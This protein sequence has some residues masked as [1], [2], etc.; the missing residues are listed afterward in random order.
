MRD[1]G[2][3]IS[4]FISRLR[5]VSGRTGLAETDRPAPARTPSA[6]APRPAGDLDTAPDDGDPHPAGPSP[7]ARENGGAR[8]PRA[9]AAA[10]AATAATTAADPAA[11]IG[12][13]AERLRRTTPEPD[14]APA[15]TPAVATRVP[16]RA[17]AQEKA[18]DWPSTDPAVRLRAERARRRRSLFVGTAAAAALVAGTAIVLA[19]RDDE[20]VTRSAP[21]AQ[22]T[23][24]GPVTLTH[25][26]QWQTVD[27][28]PPVLGV[29]LE[30]PV[31]LEPRG[32]PGFVPGSATLVA[33]RF[34]NTDAGL[35]P[36]GLADRLE[37]P[38]EGEPI[39][40]GDLE[41]YRYRGLELPGEA[42]LVDLYVL[43]TDQGTLA[44]SCFAGAEVTAALM[45]QCSAIAGSLETEGVAPVTLGPS[46][47]YGAVLRGTITRLNR[48]RRTLRTRL[49][50]AR[51]PD[52]QSRL[53]SRLASVYR[54][55]AGRRRRRRSCARRRREPADRPPDAPR[56]QQL[57]PHGRR[58]AREQPRG[59]QPRARAGAPARG[60][61]RRAAAPSAGGRLSGE[62]T[63]SQSLPVSAA[64]RARR[65]RDSA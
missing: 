12:A 56:R 20:P 29:A 42:G 32:I 30:D 8:P 10:T 28:A 16:E 36:P 64:S 9:M 59:V 57:R 6:T 41:G 24:Q 7:R 60:A 34:A 58:G 65:A 54:D 26:P 3:G 35:L 49:A 19:T 4:G 18:P 47:E 11:R 13:A 25:P 50:R 33:G 55:A 38:P 23:Q 39:R 21:A 1:A 27:P 45:R 48:D 17:E 61:S 22:R 37:T 15:P 52:G 5:P 51:T 53:S 14:T 46:A 63:R 44:V 2:G 40:V 31:A 43:A 62:L